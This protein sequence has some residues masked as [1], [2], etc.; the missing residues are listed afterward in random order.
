MVSAVQSE[1]PDSLAAACASLSATHSHGWSTGPR[2]YAR[3]DS[4]TGP[5]FARWSDDPCDV[6]RYAHEAACRTLVGSVPPLRTPPLLASGPGWLLEPW[7]DWNPRPSPEELFGAVLDAVAACARLSF[8]PRATPA[9]G[10]ALARLRQR[11]G[12][13]R[14][15]IPIRHLIGARRVFADPGLPLAGAHGDLHRGNTL[16]A[17]DGLWV[18]DWE[19]SGH[20][21]FGFDA[22]MFAASLN[23][24]LLGPVAEW[25][26]EQL[27]GSHRAAAQ[28]LAY[29]MAVRVA[30]AK[31][32]PVLS[33]DG[34]LEG[35]LRLAERLDDLAARAALPA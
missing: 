16:M 26:G 25:I 4:A 24:D 27:G 20:Q 23:A 28:R 14:S 7:V 34:D 8:P 21:P 6:T 2:H 19:L 17:A 33:T 13:L 9:G 29:A 5:V 18:V 1:P 11:V 32:V 31:L 15:G 22:I 10:S 30:S 35:G 3:L 12:L